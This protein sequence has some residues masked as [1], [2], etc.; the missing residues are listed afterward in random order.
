MPTGGEP[1]ESLLELE[2]VFHRDPVLNQP[3]PA[4]QCSSTGSA[5]ADLVEADCEQE[6]CT[7]R[8]VLPEAGYVH[9]R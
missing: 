5:G 2:E 4:D 6:Y 9:Q 8:H 1:K 7:A 3:H